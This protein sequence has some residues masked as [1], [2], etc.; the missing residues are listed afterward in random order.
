MDESPRRHEVD[1]GDPRSLEQEVAAGESPETPVA[2]FGSVIGA[3]A[4]LVLF[5]LALTALAYFLA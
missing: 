1:D 2:I 5:A 4:L 3:I